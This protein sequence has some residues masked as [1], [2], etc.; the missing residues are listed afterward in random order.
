MKT[1]SRCGRATDDFGYRDKARTQLNAYCRPCNRTYM[2]EIKR[3]LLADP[4]RRAAINERRAAWRKEN[5]DKENGYKRK[6]YSVDPAKARAAMNRYRSANPDKVA[7]WTERGRSRKQE[8]GARYG[9]YGTTR[10]DIQRM[11]DDQSGKCFLCQRAFADLPIP[12]NGTD[13]IAVDHDHATG[14]IRGLLCR[15]CNS[16]LGWY[17]ARRAAIDQYLSRP[18]PTP[19]GTPRRSP[20]RHA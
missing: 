20:S 9:K 8:L 3:R 14:E 19:C 15:R 13:A 6:A 2:R 10:D 11:L 7:V 12:R 5:R 16:G 4:E 17:E 1:C 18:R